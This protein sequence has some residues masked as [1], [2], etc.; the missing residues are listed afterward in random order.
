MAALV[1]APSQHAVPTTEPL[2][3]FQR[4][5]PPAPDAIMRYYRLSQEAGFY[6]NGGPCSQ[7]LTTRLS[8]YL[9][10]A[11]HCVTVG[12]CTL[13]LMAALRAVCGPPADGRRMVLTPSY[14][15]TATACAIEWAGFE[16]VFV[17]IERRGWHID[18]ASLEAA[19]E[20]FG[21]QV[22]GVLAC[23][24]FGTAPVAE[25]RARWR[26]LCDAQGVPLLI[27]SAPGFGSRDE[28]GRLLGG[29]G[30][31]E[32]FSFHATKPFSIGEGGVV[33]TADP[34][35]AARIGRMINFG[36]EPGT[37]VSADVGLN[38][39]MSELHAAAGLAMLDRIDEVVATR[40]RNAARLR[41]AIGADAHL[42]YQAGSER[43]TWQIFHVLCPTP[44]MR[45]RV[46]ALAPAHGI[47]V[48][49]MH[50]PALHRHPAFAGAAGVPLSVTDAASERA[51]ALPMA[52]ELDDDAVARIAGLVHAARLA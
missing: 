38:G 49:T 24:T 18:P 39:K 36:L 17:D 34:E 50:D 42:L 12:N 16:P 30:D 40:Q 20:R 7:L 21:E 47:Q 23:A 15:F 28:D 3:P 48:R 19:L 27:D 5:V 52:N 2:V 46:V 9:G 31:T 29:V 13:G 45:D 14:T 41:E 26:E 1:P 11:T 37:R 51:L 44:A 33:T 4:P 8:Q 22:A 32:I 25:Q 6:S 35:V 10:G 43:S